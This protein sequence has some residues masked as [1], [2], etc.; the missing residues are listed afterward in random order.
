MKRAHIPEVA[1]DATRWAIATVV[2][3]CAGI[4]SVQFCTEAGAREQ[5]VSE[6]REDV[7]NARASKKPTTDLS[8]LHEGIRSLIRSGSTTPELTTRRIAHAKW[9]VVRS[10]ALA[11]Q[12]LNVP[13]AEPTLP[14]QHAALPN[15]PPYNGAVGLGRS[16]PGGDGDGDGDGGSAGLPWD[17]VMD[18][19]S[20][21]L[22]AAAMIASALVGA[23]TGMFLRRRLDLRQI[24]LGLAAGFTV[25]LGLW[26][27]SGL[28]TTGAAANLNP[29]TAAVLSL[30][31]GLSTERVFEA[32]RATFASRLGALSRGTGDANSR[33]LT[34]SPPEAA[35]TDPSA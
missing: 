9:C 27:V 1:W 4:Q 23:L 14:N 28:I 2:L 21:S 11:E 25:W 35:A 32:V 30:G 7:E 24:P 18:F 13:G 22:M 31:A 3:L 33:P 20:A 19:S 26:G 34:S 15:C 5:L 29:Y 10:A 12:L 8:V 6:L 16:N 17:F